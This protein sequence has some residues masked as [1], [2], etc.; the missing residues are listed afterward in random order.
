MKT[1]SYFLALYVMVANAADAYLTDIA[2][3]SGLATELNPLMA[4]LLDIGSGTF[5]ITKLCM[6]SIAVILLLCIKD[7]PAAQKSLWA[8]SIIYTIVLLIHVICLFL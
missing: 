5:Y 8:G 1:E 4:Y 2:V 7:Q 6:V 3:T